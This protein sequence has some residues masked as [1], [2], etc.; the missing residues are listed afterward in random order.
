MEIVVKVV[1]VVKNLA[2]VIVVAV[3]L[4]VV[5][6]SA[7][8]DVISNNTASEFSG[9]NVI[10]LKPNKINIEEFWESELGNKTYKL[11]TYDCTDFSNDFMEILERYGINATAVYGILT[12]RCDYCVHCWIEIDG[13]TFEA[14][15]GKFVDPG[16]YEAKKRLRRCV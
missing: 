6:L 1:K 15:A 13:M 10:T 7:N 16:I 5:P 12:E 11:H 4:I 9:T 2:I 8:T 3:H 14:T